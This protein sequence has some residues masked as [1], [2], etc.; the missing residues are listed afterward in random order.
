MFVGRDAAAPMKG[1]PDNQVG[2]GLAKP[3]PGVPVDFQGAPPVPA[4]LLQPILGEMNGGERGLRMTFEIDVAA[5]AGQGDGLAGV[6]LGR[7]GLFRSCELDVGHRQAGERG[8]RGVVVG[9]LLSQVQSPLMVA[10]RLRQPGLAPVDRG[11]GVQRVRLDAA[12]AHVPGQRHR[13]V[14]EFQREVM[15][16]GV[17]VHRGE[18]AQGIDLGAA[19][20]RDTAWHVD[21]DVLR[22]TAVDTVTPVTLVLATIDVFNLPMENSERSQLAGEVLVDHFASDLRAG[23]P[24]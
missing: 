8:D 4:G 24:R 9:G 15:P 7:L 19:F 20:S 13:L 5:S 14:R 11:Q 2:V 1:L 17:A 16:A 6:G 23:A 18:D 22:D 10:H 3:M 21:I 12:V